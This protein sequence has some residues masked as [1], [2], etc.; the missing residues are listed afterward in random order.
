MGADERD[1]KSG[2]R[3]NKTS[4]LMNI[5]NRRM[6]RAFVDSEVIKYMEQSVCKL[7]L[8][9]GALQKSHYIPS[10]LYAMPA[11]MTP[12]ALSY[13]RP[14]KMNWLRL[15]AP[16][17]SEEYMRERLLCQPCTGLFDRNG[18]AEVLRHVAA[19]SVKSLPLSEKLKSAIPPDRWEDIS[20]VSGPSVGVDTDKLAYFALSVIC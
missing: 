12:A 4:P 9:P 15:R 1:Q 10:A 11:N 14:T 16:M 13:V 17:V 8:R 7:C 20:V 2:D 18:E 6:L 3:K 5:D 19:K